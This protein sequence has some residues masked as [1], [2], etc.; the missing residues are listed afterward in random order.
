MLLHLLFSAASL[1]AAAL[2]YAA[3]PVLSPWWLFVLLPAFYTGAVLA[4]VLVVLAVPVLFMPKKEE[5]SH[6]PLY[7]GIAYHTL[8]WLVRIL[9]YRITVSGADKLPAAPFL[10]VCNHRSAFDPLI[11]I[12]GL[13][14]RRYLTFVSKPEVLCVPLLGRLMLHASF[15]PIDRDNPR[16]AIITIRRA[17]RYMQER[18]LCMG[19]YP[20]GTRNKGNDLL[21]FHNGVF[22]IAKQADS[23]IA[24]CTIRY[25][26]RQ[27]HLRVAA[28]LDK[29]FVAANPN[30]V[31]GEQVRGIMEDSLNKER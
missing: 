19:I 17:A 12:A 13:K 31:I 8:A 26:G 16:Q 27:V 25:H 28:V 4:Y 3:V 20:E 5:P 2:F 23:P 6:K 24:V 11:T 1:A 15:L 30:A 7:R 29:E 14:N 21:P 18:G 10:L 9:G 22:K